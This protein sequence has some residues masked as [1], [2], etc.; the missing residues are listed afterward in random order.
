MEAEIVRTNGSGPSG[1]LIATRGPLA[2]HSP[3]RRT[4]P[5]AP[6]DVLDRGRRDGMTDVLE[7]ALDPVVPPGWVF[8]GHT[9]DERMMH[10]MAPELP[11]PER[12]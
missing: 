8:L 10:L 12:L 6:Q 1:W 3:A 5:V 2:P 9:D 4:Y 7:R 11:C